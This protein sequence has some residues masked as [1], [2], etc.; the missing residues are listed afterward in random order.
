[1]LVVGTMSVGAKKSWS[2]DRVY[3]M[4]GNLAAAT[5]PAKMRRQSI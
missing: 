3:H 4:A 5:A 2:G 1:M